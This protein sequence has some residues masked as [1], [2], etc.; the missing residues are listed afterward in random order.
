VDILFAVCVLVQ[1][2]RLRISPPMI[3]LAASNF[4]RRLIGVQGGES[5]IFF[6]NF[7]PQKPKI[8]R[9]GERAGLA[10]PYV[11]I[12]VRMLQQFDNYCLTKSKSA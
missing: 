4:A 5:P 12:T 10:H 8:G 9:I 7:S 11:N 1:F 2:V 6:V 3:K